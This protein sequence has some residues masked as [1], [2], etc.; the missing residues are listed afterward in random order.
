MAYDDADI[1]AQARGGKRLIYALVCVGLVV[2]IASHRA[3]QNRRH[4][5]NLTCERMRQIERALDRYAIDNGGQIPTTTQG[6]RALRTAPEQ[7]PVPRNWCG[8]YINASEVIFDG[9][10]RKLH[11]VSPGGGAPARPYDLWSLGRDDAEGG[12]DANADINSWQPE[13]MAR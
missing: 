1:Q 2:G 4:A 12:T 8:P 5:R 13:T 9:W 7:P 10:G 3:E 11:F 6:L